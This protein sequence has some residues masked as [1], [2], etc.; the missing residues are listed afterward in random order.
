MDRKLD[1]CGKD[2]SYVYISYGLKFSLLYLSTFFYPCHKVHTVQSFKPIPNLFFLESAL[3]W[4]RVVPP[5]PMFARLII[6]VGVASKWCSLQALM[7]RCHRNGKVTSKCYWSQVI[8]VNLTVT[9]SHT[10]FSDSGNI[11]WVLVAVKVLSRATVGG[12]LTYLSPVYR[13]SIWTRDLTGL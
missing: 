11:F 3:I 9:S 10:H 4:L 5:H 6:C 7:S 1:F 12:W 2:I 13:A 8:H